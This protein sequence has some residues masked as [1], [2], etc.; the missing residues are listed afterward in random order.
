[1]DM[2]ATS[3]QI[4][5]DEEL[6]RRLAEEMDVDAGQQAQIE[7]DERLAQALSDEQ[8]EQVQSTQ[9]RP[10]LDRAGANAAAQALEALAPLRRRG[11]QG[12]AG[13]LLDTVFQE[14]E[15][16]V[17]Q[18]NV[19]GSDAGMGPG[20][21]E[22]STGSMNASAGVG[23]IT[24]GPS[25]PAG[26]AGLT[27]LAGSTDGGAAVAA[28]AASA[29]L[30]APAAPTAPAPAAR[31]SPAALAEPPESATNAAAVASPSDAAA[32]AA[33]A[34]VPPPER[35]SETESSAMSGRLSDYMA[36]AQARRDE[37]R[38][39]RQERLRA[40]NAAL[41][42]HMQ[43]G[44]GGLAG[45]AGAE[46]SSGAAEAMINS[47]T[48]TSTWGSGP[49]DAQCVICVE[50]LVEGESVRTLPCGHIYHQDCIDL[51]LRRSRL[52]CLCKLPI[53]GS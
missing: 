30:V 48:V 41:D 4:R 20:V 52:C 23:G 47:H 2:N 11:M 44:L 31:A 45:L 16:L 1:M 8:E 17:H 22:P 39:R 33:A 32:A 28:A 3:E 6:A 29:A 19:N 46:P 34:A 9:R 14:L 49:S 5:C 53:D 26:P 51:W 10:R 24:G 12:E 42:A 21:S 27:G 18:V 37:T 13:T 25:S 50:D 40:L 36:R 35:V 7:A 38:R 43:A 15:E